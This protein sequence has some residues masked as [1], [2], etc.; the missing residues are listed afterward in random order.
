MGSKQPLCI[1]VCGWGGGL[2]SVYPFS[3]SHSGLL[4]FDLNPCGLGGIE[5]VS[6]P[7]KSKSF[8]IFSNPNPHGI[9]I[10]EQG[11]MWESPP[12]GLPLLDCDC[13]SSLLGLF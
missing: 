3:R 12:L 11:L 5:W 7:N 6:I 9:G 4:R 10:T 1:S 8:I 2:L 13:N